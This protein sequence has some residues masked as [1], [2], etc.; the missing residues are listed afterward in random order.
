ML[1]RLEVPCL[2]PSSKLDHGRVALRITSWI[3]GLRQFSAVSPSAY[4]P[5]TPKSINANGAV[6][7]ALMNGGL[8]RFSLFAL[9]VATT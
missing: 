8:V 7:L 3:A 5:P 9:N 1:A 6:G 2:H 4:R